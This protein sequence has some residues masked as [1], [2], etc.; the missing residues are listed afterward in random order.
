MQL[1][2]VSFIIIICR[3]LK[4]SAIIAEDQVLQRF[5]FSRKYIWKWKR[6]AVNM[7]KGLQSPGM[8]DFSSFLFPANRRRDRMAKWKKSSS[9]PPP[10]PPEMNSLPATWR[11]KRQCFWRIGNFKTSLASWFE[12]LESFSNSGYERG[13][14]NLLPPALPQ[15]SLVWQRKVVEKEKRGREVTAKGESGGG[16]L[17]SFFRFRPFSLLSS[18]L[19]ND[20]IQV[21]QEK[22]LSRSPKKYYHYASATLVFALRALMDRQQSLYVGIK[23]LFW[24]RKC[25]QSRSRKKK[26][27][28]HTEHWF[29]VGYSARKK[30]L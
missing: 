16:K 1:S 25:L 29:D 19:H 22:W 10:P 30:F 5:F 18:L 24:M 4:Y 13:L 20:N 28:P 23:K 12:D 7:T 3:P 11:G 2:F 27:W 14:A 15:L 6:D 17:S 21:T 26:L 9:P 8:R